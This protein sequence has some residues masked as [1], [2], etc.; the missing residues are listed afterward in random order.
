MD[1]SLDASTKPNKLT[2]LWLVFAGRFCLF[3][4]ELIIGIANHSLS[5]I[6]GSGHLFSD[7]LIL[8]LTVLVSYL[9]DKNPDNRLK[10]WL[11]I[12]NG[13]SLLF[14][15]L[16]IAYEAITHL[17][18]SEIQQNLSMVIVAG[19]SLVFNGW[20]V[21]I[22]RKDSHDDLNFRGFLL[23]GIADFTTA[24]GVLF[25]VMSAYF[26]HWFWVDSVVSLLIV[27][28]L[29]NTAIALIK[30]SLKSIYH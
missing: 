25:S 14:L 11:V 23:H 8:G 19:F 21:Y 17:Q 9:Q 13:L 7:L 29:S 22:L 26:W 28:V 16:L 1:T 12:A 2:T 5:L 6:A 15:S 20:S 30:E 3:S 18:T 24:L 4:A 27:I 10:N